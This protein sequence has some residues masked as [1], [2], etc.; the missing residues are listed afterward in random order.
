MGA[1]LYCCAGNEGELDLQRLNKVLEARERRE[2]P[3][4]LAQMENAA[5][6]GQTMELAEIE[7]TVYAKG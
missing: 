4:T 7:E 1:Y 6:T 5:V 2:E 3:P